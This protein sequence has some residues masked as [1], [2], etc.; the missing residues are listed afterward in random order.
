MFSFSSTS[1][2]RLAT[3]EPDIQLVMQE[4]IK[5]SRVDFGIAC[6]HRTIE[7][8]QELYKQGRSKPGSKVTNVDGVKKKSQHN[9]YPSRAIDLY[10]YY[11]GKAQWDELHLGII[12]GHILSVADRLYRDGKI[13]HKLRS[14][15]D[16]NMN[17]IYKYDQT[18]NDFPHLELV[19]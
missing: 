18:L 11:N 13:S 9:F 1:L 2:E 7:E 3:C 14:G 8:Q 12:V 16:W 19:K 4:S 10:A 5:S 6:G 15:G 17:G